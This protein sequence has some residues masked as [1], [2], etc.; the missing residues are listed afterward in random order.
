MCKTHRQK[1]TN[2]LA[3]EHKLREREAKVPTARG[4]QR[5]IRCSR[6]RK[7]MYP[8]RLPSVF[9]FSRGLVL[10][11]RLVHMLDLIVLHA[12]GI[13]ENDQLANE[14]QREHLDA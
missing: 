14:A 11:I 6:S 4:S 12:A 2:V 7:E 3:V 9:L 1:G 5:V 13:Y 8:D 10:R